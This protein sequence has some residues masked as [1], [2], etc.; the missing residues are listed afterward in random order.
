MI[1][2]CQLCNAY[3]YPGDKRYRLKI[4]ICPDPGEDLLTA[5][6]ECFDEIGQAFPPDCEENPWFE[7]LEAEDAETCQRANL[8]VCKSC[9]DRLSRNPLFREHLLFPAQEYQAK[10]IH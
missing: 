5:A 3:L 10:R 6:Q 8:V 1:C 4:C 9:Q 7:P 2:K